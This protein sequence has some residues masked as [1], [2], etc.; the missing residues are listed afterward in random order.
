MLGRCD[1]GWEGGLLERV[2][3]VEGGGTD[4]FDFRYDRFAHGSWV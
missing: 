1:A 3:G 4:N 2:E